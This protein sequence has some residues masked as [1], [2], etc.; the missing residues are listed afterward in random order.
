[1]DSE[2]PKATTAGRGVLYTT[3]ATVASAV[4]LGMAMAGLG[5]F[6]VMGGWLAAVGVILLVATAWVG[7][8]GK[9]AAADKLPV[10]PMLAFFLRVGV[11]LA[12]FNALMFVDTW[13]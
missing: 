4:M 12:L 9:I 7:L 13:L 2:E 5:V 10:K 11:Y 6:G 8:P 1:M 3:F